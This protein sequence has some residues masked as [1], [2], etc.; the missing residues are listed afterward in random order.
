[1][2]DKSRKLQ[3]EILSPVRAGRINNVP[4]VSKVTHDNIIWQCPGDESHHLD[5]V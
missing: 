4:V 3:R 5:T 2:L 1:M